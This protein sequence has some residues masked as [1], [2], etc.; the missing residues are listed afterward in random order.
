MNSRHASRRARRRGFTLL[1][2]TVS[3]GVFL[4]LSYALVVTL[5]MANDSQSAV[6]LR[7]SQVR[8]ARTTQDTFADELRQA[9]SDDVQIET[10]P[11]GNHQL[12]LRQP[13]EVAGAAAW[14]VFDRSLGATDEDRNRQDWRV[15]YTVV[16]G[17]ENG[18]TVRRLVRQIVDE[19]GAVQRQLTL[20][21]GLLSGAGARPG[22]Q[23][24]RV[25]DVW[26][27]QIAAAQHGSN[28]HQVEDFH[29]GFRN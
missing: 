21:S 1:E 2:T 16:E 10:L 23:V 22:F 11:D 5:D 17:A 26:R 20:R 4:V 25:G 14:G 12:S 29:V 7:S 28:T 24:T 15:R 9:D 18:A 19:D 13:I 8:A 3:L 27:V 6:S